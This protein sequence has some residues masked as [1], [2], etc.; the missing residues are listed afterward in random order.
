VRSSDHQ[1]EGVAL[2][3]HGQQVHPVGHQT[4]G[5]DLQALALAGLAEPLLVDPP[6]L[7]PEEGFLLPV[8][9][10]G[11][12]VRQSR[13]NDAS[14]TGMKEVPVPFFAETY[15]STTWTWCSRAS[16]TK[17]T[18]TS[19]GSWIPSRLIRDTPRQTP[20]GFST[21]IR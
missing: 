7:T 14:Q 2:A 17:G 20:F 10:V 1:G 16:S 13:D 5:P 4:V 6:A 12:V 9:T 11:D 21:V 8:F 19:A 18:S 15:P 3:R